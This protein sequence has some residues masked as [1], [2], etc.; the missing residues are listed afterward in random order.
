[1]TKK[2]KEIP[3]ETFFDYVEVCEM[4]GT[5]KFKTLVS[6]LAAF[7]KV[8][9]MEI[10]K[11]YGICPDYEYDPYAF[12]GHGSLH[13]L[14]VKLATCIIKELNRL[15]QGYHFMFFDIPEEENVDLRIEFVR[16]F[17]WYL[18]CAM[19]DMGKAIAA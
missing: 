3:V 6:N 8:R 19:C 11:K 9:N 7:K 1:M 13:T 12:M 14:Q 16:N 17:S 10:M 2:M 5:N 18:E 15:N 4:I